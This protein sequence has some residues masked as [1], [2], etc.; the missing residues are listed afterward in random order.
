MSASFHRLLRILVGAVISVFYLQP[1]GAN[2]SVARLA[3]GG[4]VLA[5][6]KDIEMRSEYLYV[7]ERKINVRYRFFNRSTTDVS[8][9]VAF[10]MP[11]L[12]PMTEGD[13]YNL[14]TDDPLN[15][16]AF[17]TRVNGSPI[18]A[19]VEQRAYAMGLERTDMLKAHA[20]P[21]APHL[22]QTHEAL[23]QLPA[24]VAREFIRLGIVR[25]ETY[26]IGR[27]MERHFFP[28][29]T[30]RTTYYWNQKFPAQTEVEV[31]HEYRPSV[32]ASAG[33]MIGMADNPT[34]IDAE[35]KTRYCLDKQFI[36]AARRV[37]KRLRAQDGFVSERRLE[38]ILTTGSNWAGPI[39]KFRL[40]VDKGAPEN[41]V[42]F[43]ASGVRKISPTRFEV[44]KNNYWPDK[45][46][47]VLILKPETATQ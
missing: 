11:D 17:Q 41:L 6:T 19:K 39:K 20:V 23:D 18:T 24:D 37:Q 33:T 22:K 4:L 45:E 31:E 29:W 38:Y 10:P 8:T 7:S 5:H 30:L 12:K 40:V 16:L 27:G 25:E 13:D 36:A 28:S 14:P 44:Q 35:T 15:F 3:A 1:A 34:G 21:V 46:L 26:D 42:S 32:G 43:C 47:N 9:L 2:D